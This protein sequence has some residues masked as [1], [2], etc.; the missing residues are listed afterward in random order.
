MTHVERATRV[1]GVDGVTRCVRA[2][3]RVMLTVNE[4]DERNVTRAEDDMSDGADCAVS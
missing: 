1:S 4:G 3:L 2:R